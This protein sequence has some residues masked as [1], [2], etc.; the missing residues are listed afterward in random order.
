MKAPDVVVETLRGRIL[1]GLRAGTLNVGARLPS[2]R[3]LFHEFRVEHRRIL[4]A[5]R[6]LANEGLVEI[7]ERGGVYVARRDGHGDRHPV[8]ATWIVDVLADAYIREIPMTELGEVFRRSTETL[9]LRAVVVSSSEEQMQGI[10]EELTADF[11]LLADGVLTRDA[12]VGSPAMSTLRRAD[13]LIA[14]AAHAAEVSKLAADLQKPWF[15]IDLRPE[16]VAGEW[17]MLLR[18]EVWAIVGSREFG[19]LLAQA[20]AHVKGGENLHILVHG[21][22]DLSA[23]PPGAAVYVTHRVKEALAD[24]VLNGIQLPANRVIAMHSTRQIVDFIIHANMRVTEA[25]RGL[26]RD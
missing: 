3:E 20:F 23:I 21:H 6:V 22:D 13:L 12:R 11:G 9:R 16:F 19:A 18:Q 14:P 4:A 2:A 5:Y 26:P 10:V 17:A 24:T 8:Q 7:R 25:L 1:R 15:A